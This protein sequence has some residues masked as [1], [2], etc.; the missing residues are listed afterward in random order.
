MSWNAESG[1]M[2]RVE[3]KGDTKTI[4]AREVSPQM[5][6]SIA[7]DY[8]LGKFRVIYNGVEINSPNDFPTSKGGDSI[9]LRPYD[10]WG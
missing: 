4:D 8:G 2:V 3:V 6:I 9:E 5:L 7:K 10:E 1:S